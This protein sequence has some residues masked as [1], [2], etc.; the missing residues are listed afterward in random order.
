[1]PEGWPVVGEGVR[2]H[3]SHQLKAH[4]L[5]HLVRMILSAARTNTKRIELG[6]CQF[7][8]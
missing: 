7:H 1:M 2:R 4:H 6:G 3:R 8:V 5:H